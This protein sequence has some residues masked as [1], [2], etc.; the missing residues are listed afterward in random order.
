MDATAQA[1]LKRV[2]RYKWWRKCLCGLFGTLFTVGGLSALFTGLAHSGDLHRTWLTFLLLPIGAYVLS[3]GFRSRIVIDGSRIEVYGAIRTRS[4]D[5]SE[6]EGFRTLQSRYGSFR[7]LIL[8][9]GLGPISIKSNFNTDDD[10]RAWMRQIPD[11]DQRDRQALL[12][13]IEQ[14]Q[15]LGATPEERL[16]ALKVAKRNAT[17]LVVIAAAAAVGLN[18]GAKS[19]PETWIETCAIVLIL[20]PFAAAF[21]CLRTPLLYTAFKRRSDPRGEA[22]Y[23]LIISSLGMI[24]S[25]SEPHFVTV[26]P[27]MG[28]TVLMAFAL[29]VVLFGPARKSGNRGALLALVAFAGLYGW[30]AIAAVDVLFDDSQGVVYAA[31]VVGEHV[32]RGRS[33]TYYLRLEPW[34]PVQA[35]EDVSVLSSVYDATSLGNTVC[36][37]LHPGWLHAPWFRV[38]ACSAVNQTPEQTL[39]Q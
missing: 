8:K 24:F 35:V 37:E 23:T 33:T 6:I 36:P 31:Q 13:E 20:A 27:L 9:N 10:Y 3:L 22:S 19:W 14:Q 15:D 7:Q 25:M 29:L 30:G 28:L 18:F 39:Q 12:A 11:L 21:L 32:S 16:G 2:Y 1:A 5:L 26:E 34:G 4:V 17:A 38:R